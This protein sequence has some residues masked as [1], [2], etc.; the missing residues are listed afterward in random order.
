[1][2]PR[3]PDQSVEQISVTRGS[4]SRT[5]IELGVALDRAYRGT[6]LYSTRSLGD[7]Q[8]PAA[9]PHDALEV[10][11]LDRLQLKLQS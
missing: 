2:R 11:H 7:P 3:V 6:R 4:S 10:Q 5:A 8:D 9:G 1:M